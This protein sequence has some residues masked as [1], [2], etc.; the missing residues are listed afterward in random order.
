MAIDKK[1]IINFFTDNGFP[2]PLLRHNGRGDLVATIVL[3]FAAVLALLLILGGSTYVAPEGSTLAGLTIIVP[4]LSGLVPALA[5][6]I[7]V[8][9]ALVAY[10]SKRGQDIQADLA[11][12]GVTDAP[13]AEPPK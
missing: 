7:P 4:S 5:A 8:L 1:A 10:V 12:T 2:A 11:A 13:T 6:L 9:A 3:L